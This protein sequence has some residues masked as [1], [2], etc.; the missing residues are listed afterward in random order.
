M[1]MKNETYDILKYVSTILIPALNFF[2]LTLGK[3]WELPYYVQI[4]ATVAA[5]GTFIGACIKVSTDNY[6]DDVD[7]EDENDYDDDDDDVVD[8]EE[9][10][11]ED[12]T[13]LL[14]K[15]LAEY[16]EESK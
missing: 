16:E 1:K 9:D 3:I 8:G 11:N 14:E 13:E 15:A 7:D 10:Y 4:A 5:V 2:I 6:N 12:Q